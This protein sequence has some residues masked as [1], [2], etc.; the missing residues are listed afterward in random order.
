M[1]KFLKFCTFVTITGIALLAIA[2]SGAY[3]YLSPGLPD[4][5]SL[6][7]IKLQ[8]PLRIYSIDGKLLGEFGEKK[9]T[10]VSIKDVPTAFIQAFLAAEDDRF[11]KH[12]GFSS[13]GLARAIWQAISGSDEQTGGSTITM[14]VV[15]NYLLTPDRNI[16]RKLKELF[17]SVQIE[18]LLT[19]DQILELYLNKIFLGHQAYG[20]AAAAHVYYGK[21]IDQLSLAEM[22]VIAALPKAPSSIN[23]ISNPEEA[24]IRRDWVLQR[25]LALK[26]IDKKAYDAALQTPIATKKHTADIEVDASYAAEMARQEM[27]ALYGE[28]AYTEGYRVTTTINSKLQETAQQAVRNGLHAY[29]MRHGYRKPEAHLD[30][31]TEE[32]KK[33]IFAKIVYSDELE[34]A[35]VLNNEGKTVQAELSDGTPI[36]IQWENGL[37]TAKAYISESRYSAPPK[38]ARDIVKPGDI[39]RVKR[40]AENWHLTQ[41]PKAEAAL[42]SL[43]PHDGSIYAIVGGYGFYN[44]K[45]NRATQAKRLIGSNIKPFIYSLALESGLTAASIIDDAPLIYTNPYTGVVWAPGNDDDEYMGPIRLRQALYKSRNLVSIRIMQKLGVK[46]TIN[47]LTRFGFEKNRMPEEMSLALGTPSFTPIQVATGY[48]TFANAGFKITPYLIDSVYNSANEIIFKATPAV[49][50]KSCVSKPATDQQHRSAAKSEADSMEDLLKETP[51]EIP[52]VDIIETATS[53]DIA[54]NHYAERIMDEKAAFII[55]S[56]L[57]DTVQKGTARRALSLKRADIAGKTATTNGPTDSWFSGYHP[58]I[59]TTVWS[60]FDDNTPIGKDEYG[61][62]IAL[63]IWIEYMEV[64]LKDQPDM[65]REPPAGIVSVLINKKS[66]KRAAPGDPDAMFEYIQ[67]DLLD[68]IESEESQTTETTEQ[69]ESIF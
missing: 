9:R 66:G 44:N 54:N 12:K 52:S 64:A 37:A 32:S 3:L 28:E 63:P 38:Q 10:P 55:D 8:V 60:G 40:I 39:I 5:E 56:I 67:E 61:S 31:I 33:A 57:T 58:N 47:Y 1:T 34:A 50:C 2:L 11:Y 21:T 69:M 30:E 53:G 14:Q 7:E 48:A 24:L 13:K 6:T 22:A 26:Y 41:I 42:I 62:T 43:N 23:P 36:E 4:A 18:R 25:M 27:L 29:D 51:E 19:K 59:I 46:N 35:V 65:M 49:A 17:I 15:K 16:I 68:T 45:F 20:I